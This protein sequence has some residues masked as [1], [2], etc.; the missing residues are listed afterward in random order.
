MQNSKCRMQTQPFSKTRGE[1]VAPLTPA[2]PNA[3]YLHSEFCILNYDRAALSSESHPD[4]EVIRPSAEI[5]LRPGETIVE[6]GFGAVVPNLAAGADRLAT[7]AEAAENHRAGGVA[8]GD[9]RVAEDLAIPCEVDEL[10]GLAVAPVH[11]RQPG[12]EVRLQG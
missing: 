11:H 9:E 3:S 10:A 7:E 4:G 12:A 8:V 6:V 1:N 2:M 5:D